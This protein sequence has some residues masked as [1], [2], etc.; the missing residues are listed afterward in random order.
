MLDGADRSLKWP[1]VQ[2]P[3]VT[4]PCL[5]VAPLVLAFIVS[6]STAGLLLQTNRRSVLSFPPA[7]GCLF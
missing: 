7:G 2:S 1:L 4:L 5:I 3:F 6:L